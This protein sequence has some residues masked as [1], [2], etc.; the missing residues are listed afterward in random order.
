[1][2]LARRR[3]ATRE[4]HQPEKLT[5]KIAPKALVEKY[6]APVVVPVQPTKEEGY[7]T[8]GHIFYGVPDARAL[9]MSS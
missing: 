9:M 3:Q 8:F 6:T 2:G 7:R 4:A 1:M 5:K